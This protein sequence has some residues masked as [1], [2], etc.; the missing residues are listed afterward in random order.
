VPKS[1]KLSSYSKKV[2]GINI[3][4]DFRQVTACGL[5]VRGRKCRYI[6]LD[7]PTWDGEFAR[8]PLEI[9]NVE[10]DY[11]SSLAMANINQPEPFDIHPN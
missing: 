1:K 4:T 2:K 3:R 8:F 10:V 5:E 11:R 7:V 9:Y 6:S